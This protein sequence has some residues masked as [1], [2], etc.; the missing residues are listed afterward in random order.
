[1]IKRFMKQQNH[2]VANKSNQNLRS[3]VRENRMR[4]S[5]RVLL[6]SYLAGE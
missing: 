6:F 1:V 3:P 2:T 4:G 5:V